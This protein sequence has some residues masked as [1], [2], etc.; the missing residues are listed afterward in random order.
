[1]SSVCEFVSLCSVA[2]ISLEATRSLFDITQNKFVVFL[3]LLSAVKYTFY[4]LE[5]QMAEHQ[6][7][8]WEGTVKQ[9]LSFL[10]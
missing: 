3:H 1:V 4:W 7:R 6:I 10:W 5:L 9:G 8:D 2:K